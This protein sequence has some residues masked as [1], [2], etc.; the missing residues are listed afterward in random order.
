MKKIIIITVSVIVSLLVTIISCSKTTIIDI[1]TQ[2]DIGTSVYTPKV[3]S[4]TTSKQ[5]TL[6]PITFG[7]TVEDWNEIEINN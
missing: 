6:T 1:Y 7:V 3:K 2:R 4:D 5:D